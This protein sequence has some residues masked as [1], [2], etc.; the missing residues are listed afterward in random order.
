[1]SLYDFLIYREVAFGTSK[2][3]IL[4]IE[5]CENSKA[6][7]VFVRGGNKMVS[8]SPLPLSIH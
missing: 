1:M 7:T 5:K 3:R 2:D 4:F 6:V 8:F